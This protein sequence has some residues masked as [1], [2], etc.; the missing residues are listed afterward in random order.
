[1]LS[2]YDMETTFGYQPNVVGVNCSV[3]G[4]DI[5]LLAD[6]DNYYCKTVAQATDYIKQTYD[7]EV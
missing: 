2:D 5:Y 3:I 4:N 6:E 1:M 7:V